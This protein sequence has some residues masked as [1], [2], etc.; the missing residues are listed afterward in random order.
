MSP[1][2]FDKRVAGRKGYGLVQVYAGNGKGKTTAALGEVVRAFG[3]GKKVGIVYF[4]KGGDTHYSERAVLDRLG[5]PYVATGRDRIDPITGR[6]DFSIR[7]IDKNEARR[8]LDEARK[9]F[10]DAYDLVVLDEI[11]STT[12]LGMVALPDALALIDEKP[13]RTELV[14]TGRNAPDAFLDRAHLVTEMKLRKHYFYSGVKAR[15][16]LDY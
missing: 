16:G 8:G 7:Q 14:L 15:E 1:P 10:A 9:M 6:F 4:D 3:A 11:N 12:D 13:E 5:V 2:I